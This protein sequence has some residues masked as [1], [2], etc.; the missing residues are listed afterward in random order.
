MANNE[1]EYS[2]G[3]TSTGTQSPSLNHEMIAECAYF[4]WEK[5]GR[6]HGRD[7][8]HW[9]EAEAMLRDSNQQGAFDV[10]LL[11]GGENELLVIRTIRDATGLDLKQVKTLVEQ[12]PTAIKL[13]MN[14]EGAEALVAT[15][16][17]AGSTMEI[18]Q[19]E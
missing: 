17:A 15:L 9:L 7:V 16:Q 3:F 19:R 10:V 6:D 12:A 5:A 2:V 11:N 13:A 1:T 4:L 18:R 14:R 8:A